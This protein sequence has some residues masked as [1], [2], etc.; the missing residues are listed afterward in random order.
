MIDGLFL[1]GNLGVG[2][3]GIPFAFL[4]SGI[5]LGSVLIIVLSAVA[6]MTTLWVAETGFRDLQIRRMEEM[7]TPTKQGQGHHGPGSSGRR[8]GRPRGRTWSNHAN[9][10]TNDD[11]NNNDTPVA[12]ATTASD[13]NTKQLVA[14]GYGT[15]TPP[16]PSSGR[17]R[18]CNSHSHGHKEVTEEKIEFSSLST[19]IE[20]ESLLHL[21]TPSP[22]S[23]RL[24]S[25]HTLR[26]LQG[27]SG[28]GRLRLPSEDCCHMDH[29]FL[30]VYGEEGG[31]GEDG[32]GGE[33][34]AEVVE[35]VLRF[36]G[37]SAKS[38]YQ[39]AV[40][41]LMSIGLIAYTQVFV[42]TFRQQVWASVPEYIL[43]TLFAAV[44]V[45]L[46]CVDLAEQISIQVVMAVLRFVSL[47][48]LVLGTLVAMC[49]DSRDSGWDEDPQEEGER[50]VPLFA[51]SGFSLMFTTAI[52]S[53]L[54]QHSVPGLVRPLPPPDKQRV[55]AIFL[56]A[57]CTTG[58]FYLVIGTSSVYYFGP[59]VNQA[60]NLNFVNFSWG[61]QYIHTGGG[62]G[63]LSLVARLFTSC[64]SM[65]VVL[66]PAMDTLSVYPLIANTLGNNLNVSFPHAHKSMHSLLLLLPLSCLPE[67]C[68]LGVSRADTRSLTALGWRL[69]AAVPPIVWSMFIT[70]L[71][72]TLQFAGLCGIVVA[73]IIPALLQ[74]CSVRELEECLQDNLSFSVPSP[75]LLSSSSLSR[76]PG[77]NE[78]TNR[79]LPRA[80]EKDL[81]VV[82]DAGAAGRR[83][84]GGGCESRRGAC[85]PYVG[86][87]S[88]VRYTY[89]VLVLAGLAIVACSGQIYSSI[90]LS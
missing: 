69:V 7:M 41:L 6:Y 68:Q 17:R 40:M 57:L 78:H 45:P 27:G 43:A 32:S 26:Q 61:L 9:T 13:S 75:S 56:A 20:R 89:A 24:A 53:Q 38:G 63:V 30:Y 47:A 84:R 39:V 79:D 19:L 37:P 22:S 2:C 52:F 14:G 83:E 23:A 28:G 21:H 77:E 66:F 31:E 85:N 49:V 3:L 90:L 76:P 1:A 82:G 67:S 64:L 55:P 36:L 60:I 8:R 80:D 48:T 62:G 70:D 74:C 16:P 33:A 86:L 18:S 59:R 54:F 58:F 5:V 12:S 51:V 73:L 87:F 46:S 11:N 10:T 88:H 42:Q 44:V 72:L 34:E 35:L 15:I 29:S 65:V 71:S 4:K 50:H 81:G 25:P